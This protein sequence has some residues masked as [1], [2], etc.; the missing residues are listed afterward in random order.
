MEL[1]TMKTLIRLLL[2]YMSVSNLWNITVDD[3]LKCI[4]LV[5][6]IV[7]ILG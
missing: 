3:V 2:T 5:L 6:Y 7:Q 4:A 1:Q